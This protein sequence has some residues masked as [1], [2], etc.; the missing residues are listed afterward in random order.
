M[1]PLLG[2]AGGCT[3]SSSFGEDSAATSTVSLVRST[4]RTSLADRS[5]HKVANLTNLR[6][7][8]S[9]L[10]SIEARTL[11]QTLVEGPY[12]FA[13]LPEYYWRAN[14]RLLARLNGAKRAFD[15]VPPPTFRA[16]TLV[17]GTA[18]VGKTFI[19]GSVFGKEHPE[20]ALCKFDLRE[21]YV[22]WK[23]KG[24]VADKPDLQDG[25]LVLNTMLAVSDKSRP[26]IR[27]YLDSLGANFYVIDS[28]DEVHPDDYLWILRQVR[29]F[30]ASPERDFVHVVVF[31]RP[32]ALR[33]YWKAAAQQADEQNVKLFVLAPP[34]F[35]TTGD[36]RVSSWNYHCW[37]N[38]LSWRPNGGELESMP[39]D[40]YAHWANLS[41]PTTGQFSS[42]ASKDDS[43][44][45]SAVDVMLNRWARENRVVC[46]T[47]RNLAGNSIIREIA[48]RLAA[49][50]AQYDERAV[51]EA[52]LHAWLARETKTDNRPSVDNAEHLDLYLK[53]LEQVATRTLCR[54]EVDEWGYFA[55]GDD[56]YVAA[57][58]AGRRY[59]FPVAR[60]M[61][62]SGLAD[63]ECRGS[64][65]TRC[66]FEPAWMHRLLVDM[67]NDRLAGKQS[68]LRFVS[69]A[70]E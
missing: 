64:G 6:V 31:S 23:E 52:Y 67:H 26:R 38:K 59:L 37:K 21:L 54:G 45:R 39:L 41:F 12:Q 7:D 15:C 8:A 68:D 24:I 47:L 10:R 19:K 42:V 51:M 46:S 9:R 56:D 40:A 3:N 17:S 32:V 36:L 28:L 44:T 27:E 18:G 43:S 35:Y 34:E 49:N 50:G 2:L 5:E 22:S 58:H 30:V 70:A 55:V 29:D 11:P 20:S 14:P 1:L 53:L 61:N 16:L 48:E 33:D 25:D 66:R 69:Q 65:E 60:V 63:V 57:Q 4:G 62:H 13:T